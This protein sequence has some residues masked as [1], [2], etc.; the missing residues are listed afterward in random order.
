LG[1]VSINVR[2]TAVRK[3]AVAAADNGLLALEL[4]SGITRVKGVLSKGIREKK[5]ARKRALTG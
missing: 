3:P 5:C 1:T 4:A 2:I